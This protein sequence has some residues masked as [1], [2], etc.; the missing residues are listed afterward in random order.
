[1]TEEIIKEALRGVPVAI[2]C[3]L[4]A[5]AFWQQLTKRTEAHVGDLRGVVEGAKNLG[6]VAEAT[7]E[8]TKAVEALDSRVARLEASILALVSEHARLRDELRHASSDNGPASR[9]RR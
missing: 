9:G 5:L 4:A 2:V 6:D 7:T 3:A 8:Q 1:M